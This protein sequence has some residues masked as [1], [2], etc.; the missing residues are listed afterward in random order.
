MIRRL[1]SAE[2]I[3]INSGVAPNLFGAPGS[4]APFAFVQWQ[5]K[6]VPPNPIPLR[7]YNFELTPFESGLVRIKPAPLPGIAAGFLFLALTSATFDRPGILELLEA[8]ILSP[9]VYLRSPAVSYDFTFAPR[10]TGMAFWAYN[11]DP[12]FNNQVFDLQME[13]FGVSQ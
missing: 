3:G 1:G 8:P 6:P 10:S 13:F 4:G 5:G 12:A 2:F 11:A 9:P 7:I